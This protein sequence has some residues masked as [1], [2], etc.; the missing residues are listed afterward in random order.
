VRGNAVEAVASG[1]GH[2]TWTRLEPLVHRKGAHR[3]TAEG[4]LVD[5]LKIAVESGHGFEAAAAAQ[6]LRDQLDPAQL[7]AALRGG[8]KPGM[9]PIIR[10]SFTNLLGLDAEARPTAV[11]LVE[12]VRGVPDLANASID[13]QVALAERATAE[14]AARRPVELK[15]HDRSLWITRADVDEVA[16]RYADLALTMLKTR[17]DRAYAG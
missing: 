6:A 4:D 3:T 17:D 13:A 15:L 9:A 10:D 14:P 1:V 7:A 11:D 12:A 5:L 16:A 2:A 8:L